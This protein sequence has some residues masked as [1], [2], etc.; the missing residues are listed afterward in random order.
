MNEHFILAVMLYHKLYSISQL[1][2]FRILRPKQNTLKHYTR[3]LTFTGCP[4]NFSQPS[5][6]PGFKFLKW[7]ENAEKSYKKSYLLLFL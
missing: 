1:T 6:W 3:R 5:S 2:V 4:L 7:C